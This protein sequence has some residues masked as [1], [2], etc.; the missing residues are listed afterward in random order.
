MASRAQFLW[1]QAE[2]YLNDVLLSGMSKDKKLEKKE[3]WL[4]AIY[5]AKRTGDVPSLLSLVYN[6]PL[7]MLGGDYGGQQE[8]VKEAGV[9]NPGKWVLKG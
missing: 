8:A 1:V 2:D 9:H 6:L 4:Q 3:R 5:H 7:R